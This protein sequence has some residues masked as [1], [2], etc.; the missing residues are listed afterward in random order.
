MNFRDYFQADEDDVD[1]DDEDGDEDDD[2]E[3]D[4]DE[5]DADTERFKVRTSTL[6]SHES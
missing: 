6:E 4:D 5:S 1:T 2:D 3:N